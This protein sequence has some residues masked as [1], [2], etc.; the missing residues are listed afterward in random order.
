MFATFYKQF[1]F[2]LFSTFY[3][4]E[5]RTSILHPSPSLLWSLEFVQLFACFPS[6]KPFVV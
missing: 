4:V 2:S 6:L 5:N 3:F 1:L